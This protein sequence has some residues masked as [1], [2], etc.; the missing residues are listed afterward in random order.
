MKEKRSYG[1][2]YDLENVIEVQMYVE[3][4]YDEQDYN[5][6]I[7]LGEDVMNYLTIYRG[8]DK[9]LDG[10]IECCEGEGDFEEQIELGIRNS[11][12]IRYGR[13]RI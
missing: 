12:I 4:N 6:H 2:G 7:G 3:Q 8:E 9:E 11:N 1:F 5:I 10:L 13:K